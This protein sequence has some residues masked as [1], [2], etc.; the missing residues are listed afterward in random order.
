MNM[1]SNDS[2]ATEVARRARARPDGIYS[3]PVVG[4]AAS[5]VRDFYDEMSPK[6][7]DKTEVRI[8]KEVFRWGSAVT[9]A[10]AV[11]VVVL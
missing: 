3:L 2:D 7:T 9:G 4:R 10:A 8:A 1:D 6:E 11:A 5:G